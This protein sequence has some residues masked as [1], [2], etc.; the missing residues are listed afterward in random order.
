MSSLTGGS[1]T[2]INDGATEV[3]GGAGGG[4]DL[5]AGAT[6][7]LTADPDFGSEVSD[8]D[9]SMFQSE[10]AATTLSWSPVAA[11]THYHVVVFGHGVNWQTTIESRSINYREIA[12]LKP[13]NAYLV[14]IT[15]YQGET[16]LTEVE[17]A[18]NIPALQLTAN[19]QSK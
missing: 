3:D 15:A 4:T 18:L 19:S 16:K 2:G 1:S 9:E 8:G 12:N 13:G 11:A 14:T 5:V 10:Q 17:T 7:E 6:E